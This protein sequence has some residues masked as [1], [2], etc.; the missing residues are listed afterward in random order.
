[1]GFISVRILFLNYVSH[2]SHT[3]STLSSI[4]KGVGV[5]HESFIVASLLLL[6]FILIHL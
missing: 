1:M 6:I 2:N 4:I 5:D 3:F